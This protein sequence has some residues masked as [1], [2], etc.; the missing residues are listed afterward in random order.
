[1]A[2]AGKNSYLAIDNSG[3]TPVDLTAKIVSVGFPRTFDTEDVSTM[4]STDKKHIATKRDATA[5]IELIWDATLDAHMESI[6]DGREVTITYGPTGN[7]GG[8]ISKVGE[9]IL[10]SLGTPS[11]QG[12]VVKNSLTFQCT[13]GITSSTFA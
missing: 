4:G 12:G 10:T 3:G 6:F 2:T 8:L 1:M 13:A 7:T 5:T 11:E 9:F